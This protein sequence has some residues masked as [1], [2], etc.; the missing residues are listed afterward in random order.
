MNLINLKP[1]H[2]GKFHGQ[3]FIL[4]PGLNVIYGKNEAGKSTLHAFVKGMLFGIEKARGRQAKGDI[5]V[6]YLPW[7]T[8]GA[9]QG[10]MDFMY[11]DVTYRINRSFHIKEKSCCMIRLDTGREISLAGGQPADFIQNL[12][13][14][15]YRNTISAEQLRIK[16]DATL[17]QE[18][19]NYIANLSTAKNDEV[20]V[21][22]AISELTTKK[23]LLENHLNS[24]RMRQIEAEI[25]L[26]LQ[27]EERLERLTA[28][29]SEL[30]RQLEEVKKEHQLESQIEN[31]KK[32]EIE[33]IIGVIE[34]AHYYEELNAKI[35]MLKIKKIELE[36]EKD[37]IANGQSLSRLKDAVKRWEDVLSESKVYAAKTEKLTEA[38][39][40]TRNLKGSKKKINTLLLLC[41]LVFTIL[42]GVTLQTTGA[43]L[44]GVMLIALFSYTV[45]SESRVK[46]KLFSYKAEQKEQ[47]LLL[48]NCQNCCENIRNE[49]QIESIN[50]LK[51]LQEKLIERSARKGYLIERLAE[52]SDELEQNFRKSIVMKEEIETYI[53][54]A[55]EHSNRSLDSSLLTHLTTLERKQEQRQREQKLKEAHYEQKIQEG[56]RSIERINWEMNTY[57][58][59]ESK[60]LDY[61]VQ[62]EELKEAAEGLAIELEAVNLAISTIKGLAADIHDSFGKKLNVMVSDIVNLVTRGAYSE[63]L[64]DE[65]LEVKVQHGSLFVTLD[66]LSAGTIEQIYLALRLCIAGLF[67]EQEEMPIVLDD[68]FA[69]YDDERLR[70]VLRMLSGLK[71][72]IIIFTCQKREADILSDAGIPYNYIHLT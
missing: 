61:K 52:L 47:E 11:N 22:S 71:R 41:L 34:K 50:E 51:E 64:I 8:K 10:S 38:I 18:V 53:S 13:E 59:N 40:Q 43:V 67:F 37:K 42:L 69:L 23:K 9:Y 4:S 20:D 2:F 25:E 56:Y 29:K 12:T 21:T 58:E 66:K 45:F 55:E 65:K 60:L 44:G 70:A 48:K 24:D 6:K 30:V 1:G 7:E 62:L 39:E 32:E 72:Q 14:S 15:N 36:E 5:Y 49:F 68:S 57:A 28:Q 31:K 33:P 3:E 26:C 19:Q 46:R 54:K 16:T 17:S 63:V 27:N 35:K